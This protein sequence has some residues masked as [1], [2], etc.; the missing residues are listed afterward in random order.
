MVIFLSKYYKHLRFFVFLCIT[1]LFIPILSCSKKEVKPPAFEPKSAFLRATRLIEDDEFEKA[2]ELLTE[3]KHRDISKVYAPLAQLKIADS[4][5]RE[6]EFELAIEEYRRFLRLYPANKYAP[7]AQYQIA[8]IFYSRIESADRGYKSAEEAMKEFN[9][10]NEMFPRNPYRKVIPLRI[11]KCRNILADHELYVG[12]F[13][14]RKE[15]YNAAL[16]RLNGILENYSD[17]KKLHRVYYIIAMSYKELGEIEKSAEFFLK[18]MNSTTDKKLL[19]KVKK[20]L[21]KIE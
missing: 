5:S 8:T 9:K 19:K 15:A 13:Y 6:E 18:T 4:F 10:L 16:G 7:Y 21:K 12:E 20:E 17:Y 1:L 11:Q 14:Y 2:R 3:I